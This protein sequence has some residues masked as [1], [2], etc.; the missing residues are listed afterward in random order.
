MHVVRADTK[1][2]GL[3][4]AGTQHGAYVSF[5]DGGELAAV[6]GRPAGRAGERPVGTD[7]ALAIA[8]H[9]RSFYVMDNLATLRQFGQAPLTDVFLFAPPQ[10]IRGLD[11]AAIDYYLKAQP[12]ALTLDFLD[13][14]GQVV[15]SF[16]GQPPR[17]G[18]A[19]GRRRRRLPTPAHAAADG[20]RA[21]P[22]SPGI[23]TPRGS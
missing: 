7:N 13:A 15:R 3:L 17:E 14:K 2:K 6:Q 10:T 5:D 11:R 8:T 21:Q 20:R 22:R 9:G 23:S 12:K 16:T 4:Y 19:G 1:R 18:Q